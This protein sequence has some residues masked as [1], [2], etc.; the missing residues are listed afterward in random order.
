M[1]T[2]SLELLLVSPKDFPLE[3]TLSSGEKYLLPHPDHVQ[4]HPDKKSLV[5]YPQSGAFSL[6]VDPMHVTSVRPKSILDR[7]KDWFS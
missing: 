7:L 1:N 4:M 6:V 5:I 2:K 3:I